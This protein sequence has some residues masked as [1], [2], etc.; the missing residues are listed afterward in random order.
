MQRWRARWFVVAVMIA[1][2]PARTHPVRWWRSPQLVAQLHLTPAQC[3][4]MERAYEQTLPTQRHASVE[5]A[6]TVDAIAHELNDGFAEDRLLRL[7]QQ[8]IEAQ[9]EEGSVQGELFRKTRA[10]CVLQHAPKWLVAQVTQ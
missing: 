3:D 5:V 10:V 7:T 2:A 1:A 9:A 6:R 4:E 8:L